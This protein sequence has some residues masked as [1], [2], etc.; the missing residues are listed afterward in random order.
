MSM[1]TKTSTPDRYNLI[2]VIRAAA[3]ISMIA[4]HLCYDIFIVFHADPSLEEQ[5]LFCLWERSISFTFI[6]ISGI[7]VHFSRNVCKRGVIV[8][9]CGF[10]VTAVTVLFV[11]TEQIWFGILNM[12]GCAM[13]ITRALQRILDRLSPAVGMAVSLSLFALTYGIPFRYL[14]FFSIRFAEA[15]A[16]LYSC[17][18]LA[19]LG[20]P[21]EGFFSADFFP[22]I[23]WMFLFIFGYCLWRYLVLRGRD[24]LFYRDVPML[25]FIGRHSLIIYLLHQPVLYLICA[26]ISGRF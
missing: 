16:F 19:F 2:D 8:L 23:P 15:P 13:L 21:S 22:L 14:G 10:A 1:K 4:Y 17:R 3:I 25:S 6:I 12:I 11:P 18:Y 5:P 9:L 26:L 20:F 24:R 7:C